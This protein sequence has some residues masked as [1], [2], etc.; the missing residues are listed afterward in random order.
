MVY[1]NPL[2]VTRGGRKKNN[3][4]LL[5][6]VEFDLSISIKGHQIS[7]MLALVNTGH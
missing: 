4:F 1:V 3:F 7:L 6:S 2:I 5:A